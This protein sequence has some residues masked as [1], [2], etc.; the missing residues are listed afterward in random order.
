MIKLFILR[1]GKAVRPEAADDDYKRQLNVKGNA[2]VNQVG[3]ILKNEGIQIDQ[4]ITSGAKRAL[5]TA[6]IAN[7]YL[8]TTNFIV[9]DRLYLTSHSNIIKILGERASSSSVLLVGHNFGLSDAVN[10]LTGDNLLLST[11]M[12]V[13]IN[14]NFDNWNLLSNSTGEIVRTIQPKVHTF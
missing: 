2:Q 11:S 7:H 10:Y 6:E 8:Q 3:Y 12:L 5:Q 13:Q 14:F 4:V 9:D 1:H